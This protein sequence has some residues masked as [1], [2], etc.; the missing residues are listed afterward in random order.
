MMD[1]AWRVRKLSSM[2]KNRAKTSGVA[3]N[4]TPEFLLTLWDEQNGLCALT[5]WELD[6]TQST[7]HVVNPKAPSLDRIIPQ[8]GYTKGNVRWVAYHANVARSEYGDA[9]LMSLAKALIGV[10]V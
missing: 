5:G 6:L 10:A 2:A 4:L 3:F 9:G 1:V 8:D 7:E